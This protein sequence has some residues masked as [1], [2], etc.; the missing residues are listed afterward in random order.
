MWKVESEY[1][2]KGRRQSASSHH[3]SH[4]FKAKKISPY[5][6]PLILRCYSCATSRLDNHRSD[7]CG[8][9]TH[10]IHSGLLALGLRRLLSFLLSL[11]LITPSNLIEGAPTPTINRLPP[12]YRPT[13]PSHPHLTTSTSPLDH[14]TGANQPNS[15]T[16]TTPNPRSNRHPTSNTR[17]PFPPA[18]LLIGLPKLSLSR[19]L[20]PEHRPSPP[21]FHPTNSQTKT[22]L[23]SSPLLFNKQ[24]ILF[25]NNALHYDSSI[26]CN[27][28]QVTAGPLPPNHRY[29]SM[30]LHKALAVSTY[31][32]TMGT[33]N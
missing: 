28:Q 21:F 1:P 33:V 25:Y 27:I 15:W 31:K 17:L 30:R 18:P 7:H 8:P 12:M 10:C 29:H 5:L 32:P 14:A 13:K 24:F 4:S 22:T 23:S 11:S 26:H 6:P 2:S 16:P 19:P 9:P 20:S 3:L